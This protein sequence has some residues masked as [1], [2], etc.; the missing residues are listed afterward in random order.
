MKTS[1]LSF[2]ALVYAVCMLEMPELEWGK[3]IGLHHA[4]NQIVVPIL[5]APRCYSPFSNWEMFGPIIEREKIAL[6]PI[7]EE[8]WVD[9]N[10]TKIIRTL[11]YWSAF[12]YWSGGKHWYGKTPL[13]AAM[14]CYVASKLD[15]EIDIPK[16]LCN[17]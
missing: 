11:K 3:S 4:S 14:R 15:D 9:E 7:I 1:E 16:E 17:P 2:N 13:I 8:K 5:P 6:T 12:N 10:E